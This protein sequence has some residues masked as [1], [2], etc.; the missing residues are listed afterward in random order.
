M[1]ALLIV[2]AVVLLHSAAGPAE[3]AMKRA[4]GPRALPKAACAKASVKRAVLRRRCAAAR[5]RTGVASAGLLGAPGSFAAPAP[6][7]TAPA[8]TLDAPA[9]AAPAPPEPPTGPAL[10]PVYSNPL[11]V[12]VRAY[13][14]RFQLSKSAVAAGDVRVE[15]NL[16]GAEDP[17]DLFLVREDGT[18]PAYSFGEEP[19]GAVVSRTFPLTTG[20]WR[21]LCSLTGHEAAGMRATLTVG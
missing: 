16:S 13:E 8:P 5:R 18:G 7:A 3:A 14:F 4:G 1:R 17:H 12:Q 10:P 11:A 15:F 9:D 19:S 2:A 21:L 20:R 6:F